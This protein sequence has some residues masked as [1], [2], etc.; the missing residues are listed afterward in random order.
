[1]LRSPSIS[2][3]INPAAKNLERGHTQR[4][5]CFAESILSRAE[6]LIMTLHPGSKAKTGHGTER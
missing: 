6:G 1:M 4:L 2:L 5:R 3:R